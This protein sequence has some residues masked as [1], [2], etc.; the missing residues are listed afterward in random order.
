MCVAAYRAEHKGSQTL[1]PSLAPAQTQT[2]NPAPCQ[3]KQPCV[4]SEPYTLQQPLGM[5]YTPSPYMVNQPPPACALLR[6][7]QSRTKS[8]TV[9]ITDGFNYST[10]RMMNKY[11]EGKTQMLY[12]EGGCTPACLLK[13]M[14]M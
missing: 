10:T 4:Y 7:V 3:D 1:P 6:L 2:C 13:C 5:I 12:P 11:L 9:A 8:R 14:R